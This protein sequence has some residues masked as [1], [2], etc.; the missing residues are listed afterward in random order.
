MSPKFPPN[1]IFRTTTAN[2][3]IPKR[4]EYFIVSFKRGL[5]LELIISLDQHEFD[6]LQTSLTA[7]EAT[8]DAT[9]PI[10]LVTALPDF[11]DALAVITTYLIIV[12]LEV[13]SY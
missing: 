6:S 11:P 5:S 12:L 2:I 1:K 7:L 8:P 9:S 3:A 4:T 10:A 13:P